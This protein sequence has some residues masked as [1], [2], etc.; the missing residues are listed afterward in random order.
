MK[1]ATIRRQLPKLKTENRKRR[2][3]KINIQRRRKIKRRKSPPALPNND[4]R[5]RGGKRRK[6]AK[7][8]KKAFFAPFVIFAPAENQPRRNEER[9]G[10]F[11]S[12]FA[13]FVSSWLIFIVSGRRPSCS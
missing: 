11:C 4:R 2:T 5:Q 10:F 3:R 8:A 12:F 7:R 6:G 9:E 13:L 1:R